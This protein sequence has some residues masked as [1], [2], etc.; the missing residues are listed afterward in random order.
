MNH[1]KALGRP[2]HE[3]ETSKETP[4]QQSC[5][6]GD[7]LTG[8]HVS[9]PWPQISTQHW[10]CPHLH[11]A[12]F[13][14]STVR[15]GLVCPLSSI[16]RIGFGIWS[17]STWTYPFLFL[18]FLLPLPIPWTE[19]DGEDQL[20]PDSPKSPD[21]NLLPMQEGPPHNSRLHWGKVVWRTFSRTLFI[22]SSNDTWEIYL[23]F[24]S[25]KRL[26]KA[27]LHWK[28]WNLCYIP[29]VFVCQYL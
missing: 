27:L 12:L 26:S 2:M 13:C 4:R 24:S 9:S 6:P 16:C 8:T 21:L 28:I 17:S 3:I 10:S 20:L 25:R 18:E 15:H 11:L 5:R 14:F 1:A 29:F 19:V 7:L 22:A 23:E